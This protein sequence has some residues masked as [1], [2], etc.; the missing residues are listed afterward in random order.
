MIENIFGIASAVAEETAAVS[1]LP[2]VSAA[3]TLL[4]EKVKPIR[5]A[6]KNS[7]KVKFFLFII[8]YHF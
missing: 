5:E 4:Q 1:W 3:L 8:Q 6:V 7:E 2:S